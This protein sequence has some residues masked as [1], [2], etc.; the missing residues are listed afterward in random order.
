MSKATG[1]FIVLAALGGLL[2]LFN[3]GVSTG[4]FARHLDRQLHPVSC[5]V[6]P[7]E[8]DTAQLDK[9]V[10]GCKVAMFSEYSSFLRDRMWGGIPVSLLAMG[11]FGFALALGA[12]SLV[13]RRGHDLAPSLF[14]LFA[15]VVAAAA[16]GAYFTIAMTRLHTVCKTCVGMYIASG[17]LLLGGIMAA[18][19]AYRD[20][21][22]ARVAEASDDEPHIREH[23]LS[24]FG[25]LLVLAVE[26][27][28]AVA[29]PAAIYAATL[30]D[31]HKHVLDCESFDVA[32]E[33]GRLLLPFGGGSE[34][35]ILVLDPLC[36]ACKAFHR[37]LAASAAGAKLHYRVLLMPLDSECNWMLQDSMHPGACLASKALICAGPESEDMLEVIYE[38]QEELRLAGLG[39]KVERIR[40]A[41]LARFPQVAECLDAKETEIRLNE[42]LRVAVD[43]ALPVV[44]PQLYIHGK[45]LCDEDTDLGMEYAVKELLARSAP[46]PSEPARPRPDEGLKPVG[47]GKAGARKVAR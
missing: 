40:E 24:G 21:K 39:G 43:G 26:M 32:A 38:Q 16:S 42:T 11:L 47:G 30:P 15:G 23:G 6:L 4:D 37:R 29:L 12:W 34:E 18:V 22:V 45:R 3:A 20:R 44:T 46:P 2:G 41:I 5:S 9:T 17:I 31:Y 28:L 25:S 8:E 19:S 10:E 1:A 7:F 33:Q 27:G 35:A 14:L 36:P 13:S